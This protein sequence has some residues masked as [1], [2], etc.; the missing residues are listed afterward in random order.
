MKIIA[1]YQKQI[2]F[3]QKKPI[4][5]WFISSKLELCVSKTKYSFLRKSS[6][7]DDIPLRATK[8]NKNS[9]EIKQPEFLKLLL[10]N[11]ITIGSKV[12]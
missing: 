7:K 9:T 6:E 11:I 1:I 10:R 12:I 5:G 4:N 2:I 3:N 8:L